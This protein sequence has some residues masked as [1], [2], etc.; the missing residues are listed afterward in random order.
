MGFPFREAD[1]VY[2]SS[3]SSFYALIISVI[4]VSNFNVFLA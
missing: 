2:Y 4:V 3:L 1:E